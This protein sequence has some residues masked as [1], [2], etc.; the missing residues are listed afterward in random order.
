[1]IKQT[2]E[3]SEYFATGLEGVRKHAPYFA[4]SEV[5]QE[6]EA[7]VAHVLRDELVRWGEE[8]YYSIRSRQPGDDPPD[9]EAVGSNG[10]R[11]G[12]EVTEFVDQS[13]INAA[14]KGGQYS[15]Q[16]ITPLTVVENISEVIRK[17]GRAD[18]RGETYDRYILIIY[19]DDPL[20][21]DY[22]SLM[23]IREAKFDCTN[24]IDRAYFLTSYDPWKRC[25]PYIQLALAV[26]STHQ[27]V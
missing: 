17:K 4:L 2:C 13:A 19:C 6:N 1:M 16:S 21:L 25:C 22:E 5:K 20:F 24:L 10:E 7:D 3:L 23:A 8:S 12:I 9:C 11:V 26:D 15:H 18:V 27:D 14:K